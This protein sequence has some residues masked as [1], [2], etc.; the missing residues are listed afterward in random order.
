[1]SLSISLLYS[2]LVNSTRDNYLSIVQKYLT[3]SLGSNPKLNEE[4]LWVKFSSE[5]QE[6]FITGVKK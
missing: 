5:L 6:E 2:S 4:L 1:L 3:Q